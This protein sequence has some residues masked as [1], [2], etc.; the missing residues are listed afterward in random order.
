MLLTMGPTQ[1]TQWSSHLLAMTAEPKERAGL[2]EQPVMGMSAM[3]SRS[4][5]KPETN[6]QGKNVRHGR[7][8]R[9]AE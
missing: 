5:T 8:D 3:W 1:K 6:K 9:G 2:M 7:E 4:T